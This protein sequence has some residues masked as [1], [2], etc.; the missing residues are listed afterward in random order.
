MRSDSISAAFRKA[1][2]RAGVE[3][4]GVSYHSLRQSFATHPLEDGASL[5]VIQV[6]LGH[7]SLRTTAKTVQECPKRR[8]VSDTLA[9]HLSSPCADMVR[10]FKFAS[11]RIR[12]AV[13][14]AERR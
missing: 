3:R 4:R 12:G 5:P 14:R 2:A 8:T 9:G 10:P 11:P 6:L 1:V 13:G 7:A